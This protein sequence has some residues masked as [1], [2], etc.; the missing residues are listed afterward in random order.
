MERGP[1]RR[2]ILAGGVAAVAAG[3]AAGAAAGDAVPPACTLENRL[4]AFAVAP[5]G[6]IAGFLDKQGAKDY[7]VADSPARLA[8]ARLHGKE[9]PASSVHW[10]DGKLLVQFGDSGIR[11]QLRATVRPR[12][13]V[14]EVASVEGGPV[15]ELVFVDVPLSLRGTPEEPFAA[16]ALALNLRTNVAELP[17]P[18]SR[19]RAVCYRQ[20]GLVGAKVALVGCAPAQFREVLQEVVADAPELPHSPLG[21]P[22]AMGQPINQGS[23]LFNLDGVSQANV[24]AWIKL[25]KS[26]GMNQI[27]FHGG[28]SFRFG[29]FRP[30]PA[31]YPDG[32]A[33]LKK[34]IDR[35]H[36]AGIA[37]GLHTYAFFIAKDCP[38]VTP[39]PD[40]RLASR[41][42][43]TLA[44]PIS[45]RADAIP[46]DETTRDVSTIT[47][48]FVRNSVT[49]RIDEELVTFQGVRREPP[50]AFTGCQRGALGTKA[51]AHGKGARAEH[52]KECFG[53]LVPNPDSTLFTE[54]AAR[55]AE[56]FNDCGFD[57]MYLDALDGSDVLDPFAGGAFAWHYGARFTYE[58]WKRLKRPALM[59]MS[60]FHHH[61]WCVRSRL[62]AWDHPNRGHKKFID[63]H[64]ADNENS[65]RM[66]LPGELGWWALKSWSGPQGE[67]TFPDDV[68][69]LMARCLAT[70]TGFALM[71]I[72]PVSVGRVPALPRLADVVK[73]Y[74][75][76]RH[77]KQVPE[78][79]K[80]KLRAPGAE[81]SLVGSLQ[82][83]W[84]FH[85]VSYAKHRVERISDP[86]SR[87][88]TRNPFD[89]Q[90]LRVRIEALMA[91]GPYQ[92]EPKTIL[93]DFRSPQD[94]PTRAAQTGVIAA[95]EPAAPPPS[96]PEAAMPQRVGRFTATSTHPQRKAAWAQFQ[97]TFSPPRN[98][99]GREALGL[100]VH[101]DG[102]GE[103]LNVQLRSPA[104]VVGG[105]DDHY[106]PIDF[107]GW[108]YF[109][110]IEPEGAR[111]A[112]YQWPYGDIYSIYR[113][114]VQFGQVETLGIWLNDLPPGKPVTCYLGPLMALPLAQT[115]LIRP[116]IAIGSAA[117][118]FPVE[119]ESGCYLE[120]HAPDD[121][122]LYG[123][124]GEILRQVKPE[125]P[126][127]QLNPGDNPVEF[128]CDAPPGTSARAHVTV[129][130][131]G[132][133]LES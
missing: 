47:G 33:G 13:L 129:I 42:S 4:L 85:P 9:F 43:F 52:L 94:F 88:T 15:D 119:I 59:E 102:Q 133:R 86:S 34:V 66:L 67:P 115:R 61:L 17:R 123:P 7:A 99:T 84:Q 93:A 120:F 108:R 60:T 31:I 20:L 114:S 109:E 36:A 80:A 104:H 81:F 64:V 44:E 91:A 95:W 30:H 103:L 21:G 26:L 117:I 10:A 127:P 57:M 110:L 51:A 39:I 83:G 130:T 1:T 24:E 98:L 62:C 71:G 70:D 19:L 73:R 79:I 112:D 121:C 68:E 54:V 111:H 90:P 5:D 56:T 92:A 55:T 49:L 131:R 22:W 41:A 32:R 105:I 100:W 65:R 126:V 78:S 124:Q 87:W 72:D 132:R 76:L 101:G 3:L 69:Y 16:C 118:V 46:V 29:D 48:F 38:W 106:V 82:S 128:R 23:Y 116:T 45:A 107:T 89:R 11:A 50:F 63:L 14:L 125:G 25:A 113:E 58:I 97:T 28:H 53:L 77:A 96:P 74:E 40:P 37:A 27:D 122:K 12:Y 35:L 2:Q 75:D 18:A 8:V 6:R